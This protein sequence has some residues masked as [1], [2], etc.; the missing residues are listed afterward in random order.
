[1]EINGSNSR[2]VNLRYVNIRYFFIKGRVERKELE[3]KYF[4]M[5]LILTGFSL[6]PCKALFLVSSDMQ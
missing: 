2:T 4:P 1:M 6:K 3:M 5:H